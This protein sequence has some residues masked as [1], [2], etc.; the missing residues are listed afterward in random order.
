MEEDEAATAAEKQLIDD[1]FRL[2]SR[3][4]VCSA[5]HARLRGERALLRQYCL[6]FE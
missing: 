4:K 1:D 2:G 3:G 5:S 6:V